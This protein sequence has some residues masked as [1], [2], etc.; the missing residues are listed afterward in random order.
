[1]KSK[2]NPAVKKIWID[3]LR[4]GLYKQGKHQLR[5]S[6][7]RF[8]TLGVL[9]NL[10]AQAHPEIAAKQTNLYEYLGE[11]YVLPV[12]AMKWAGLT[13]RG[14]MVDTKIG[15]IPHLNDI[16]KMTFDEIADVIEEYL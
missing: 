1:M 3:A 4:S 7:D 11:S 16:E 15:T 2:M 6:L 13:G 5:I 10:H 12:E 9:C 14:P 8:C